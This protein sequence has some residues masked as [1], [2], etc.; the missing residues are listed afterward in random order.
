MRDEIDDAIATLQNKSVQRAR[1]R[2]REAIL[3]GLE[4]ADLS[5]PQEA[6]A[7]LGLYQQHMNL[8][9]TIEDTAKRA[10]LADYNQDKL[11]SI[12]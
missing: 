1:T 11:K 6:I 5:N 10:D 8:W 9:K 2:E 3:L 12:K 7:K 4:K